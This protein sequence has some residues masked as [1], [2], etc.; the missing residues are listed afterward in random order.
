MTQFENAGLVQRHNFDNGPALYELN[1]GEHHDHMICVDSGDVLEF[2]SEE[3]EAMQRKVAEDSGYEL[4]GH[5]LV[6]Y[7]KPKDSDG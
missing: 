2:H 7:V 1:R 3:I 5:S 6:L 4:I